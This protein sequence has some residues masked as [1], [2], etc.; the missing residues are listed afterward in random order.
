MCYFVKPHTVIVEYV[1][2]MSVKLL[3]KYKIMFVDIVKAYA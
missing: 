2:V 1:V 3:Q